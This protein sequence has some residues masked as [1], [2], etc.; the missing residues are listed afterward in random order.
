MLEE[1]KEEVKREGGCS[2]GEEEGPPTK[3]LLFAEL[4]PSRAVS[5]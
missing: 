4:P 5:L 1:G 2:D 3:H